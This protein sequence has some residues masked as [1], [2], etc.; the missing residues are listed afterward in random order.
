[1]ISFAPVSVIGNPGAVV[2]WDEEEVWVASVDPF[3]IHWLASLPRSGW[4]TLGDEIILNY[5]NTFE[6]IVVGPEGQFAETTFG[7]MAEGMLVVVGQVRIY[8]G[9]YHLYVP[10]RNEK[11][12]LLLGPIPLLELDIPFIAFSLGF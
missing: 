7:G 6:F 10:A 3:F 12:S 8:K 11:E 9:G 4:Y 2:D 5:I 1:M